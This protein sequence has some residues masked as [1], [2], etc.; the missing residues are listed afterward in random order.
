MMLAVENWE[1]G[2]KLCVGILLDESPSPHFGCKTR[3]E[4]W[5]SGGPLQ[6]CVESAT[7]TGRA[8]LYI[9]F[10][11]DDRQTWGSK[12]VT[13]Y[14]G[15]KLYLYGTV[16]ELRYEFVA[17]DVYDVSSRKCSSLPYRVVRHVQLAIDPDKASGVG[18]FDALLGEKCPGPDTEHDFRMGETDSERTGCKLTWIDQTG[19][20]EVWFL[21]DA[22]GYK[23]NEFMLVEF[24]RR[25]YVRA[26]LDALSFLETSLSAR[27]K[28]RAAVSLISGMVPGLDALA[29]VVAS[30]KPESLPAEVTSGRDNRLHPGALRKPSASS[31]T[32]DAALEGEKAAEPKS[33]RPRKNPTTCGPGDSGS[34]KAPK[35]GAVSEIIDLDE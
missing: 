14:A 11:G 3:G 2:G 13:C 27:A 33:K 32:P 19:Y 16:R 17:A 30:P 5:R 29:R 6:R 31:T 21:G 18:G 20:S 7:S 24:H 4:P 35:V 12:R 34:A 9:V 26:V 28:Q 23:E 1:Q 10:N 8:D 15:G 22:R 25:P